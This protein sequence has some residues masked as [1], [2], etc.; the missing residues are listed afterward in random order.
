[1][2][3]RA[4][5][6]GACAPHP[7]RQRATRAA[8][9]RTLHVRS[10]AIPGPACK[11]GRVNLRGASSAAPR[12]CTHLALQSTCATMAQVSHPPQ[13]NLCRATTPDEPDEPRPLSSPASLLSC[14]SSAR[15]S[16]AHLVH[17]LHRIRDAFESGEGPRVRHAPH[18]PR[19]AP[20]HTTQSSAALLPCCLAALL[21]SPAGPQARRP[22]GPQARRPAGPCRAWGV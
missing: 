1:M 11:P 19:P 14:L 21:P 22:A 2:A 4:I 10:K 20:P 8:C 12:A 16:P 18:L 5:Q 9:C 17:V 3:R 7:P 6:S 15:A 13:M